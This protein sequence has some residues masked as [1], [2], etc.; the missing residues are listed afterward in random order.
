MNFSYKFMAFNAS[1]RACLG[2]HLALSQLQMKIVAVKIIQNYDIKI[3]KGH[4]IEAATRLTLRSLRMKH[5][6]SVT[7]T[8][9]I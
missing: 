6:L 2:K 8:K 9:K 1:P 3:T 7:V 5:G 4:K